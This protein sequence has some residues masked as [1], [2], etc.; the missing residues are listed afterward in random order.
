M[1]SAPITAPD[2]AAF[3]R[4]LARENLAGFW[5]AR[6]PGHKP[7]PPFLWP[8]ATVHPALLRAAQ[9]IGM[10]FAERR[11]IKL[12]NPAYTGGAAS[13]TIQFNFSV[14]NPGEV[15]RAHRHNMS[16]IRFVVAGSGAWTTVEGER[17]MM[18][19][20]DLILTPNWTWHDHHNESSEP[21][22][23]LD[24]LDGPLMQSLNLAVFEGYPHESQP[25]SEPKHGGAPM[26]YP[27]KD[28][29]TALLERPED[30][31]DGRLMRYKGNGPGGD[32]LS[33]L[34]C[35][36]Q[37]LEP[38][39]Q[40]LR[41][42][43]TNVALFHVVEGSGQTQV[44]DETLTWQRGDTFVIP[45]WQWYAHHNPHAGRAVLFSMNDRP[46]LTGLQLYREEKA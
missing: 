35:E 3:D 31:H 16:A 29:L 18:E 11:V 5:T 34:G 30:A 23:W 6:V 21:I 33:T 38:G 4:D 10:D 22:I 14:V 19:P 44:G 17:L 9:S 13:R 7:E 41:K 28:A 42:R 26:R 15:A 1:S 37:A 36:L 20:G 12:V 45:A 2:T 32:T 25:V 39:F 43:H 40:A 8:W 27:Y 24:G 46:A